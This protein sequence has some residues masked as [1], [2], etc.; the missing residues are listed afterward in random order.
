MDRLVIGSIAQCIKLDSHAQIAQ[1]TELVPKNIQD[2]A[3]SKEKQDYPIRNIEVSLYLVVISIPNFD[4]APSRTK[5]GLGGLG[6]GLF[7][8]FL[9]KWKN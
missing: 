7:S 9:K 4:L 3:Q 2:F 6:G 8:N 5:G 1:K